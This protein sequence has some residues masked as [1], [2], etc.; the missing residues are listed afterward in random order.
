MQ[1]K[2]KSQ[3]LLCSFLT[4]HCDS[5]LMTKLLISNIHKCLPLPDSMWKENHKK[6]NW[7]KGVIIKSCINVMK[8]M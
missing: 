3:D 2:K 6:S 5:L 1:E 7:V 4:F 8:S